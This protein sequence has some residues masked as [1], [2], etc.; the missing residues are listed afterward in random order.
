M[1]P[2]IDLPAYLRRI[3]YTSPGRPELATLRALTAHHA[4]AI[5]FENL[6]PLSG[7]PARLELAAIE[8]KIVAG[9]RGGYCFEQNAL[10]AAGLEQLGYTVTRLPPRVLWGAPGDP[11]PAARP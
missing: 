4:A 1:D 11:V 7:V 10:F 8:D 3:G 5:P 2:T 6:D 9:G